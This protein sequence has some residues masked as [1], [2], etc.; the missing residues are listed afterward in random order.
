L[1]IE[2]AGCELLFGSSARAVVVAEAVATSV[3]NGVRQRR[4]KFPQFALLEPRKMYTAG[5]LQRIIDYNRS[6]FRNE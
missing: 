5:S 2:I 3:M 1:S 4:Q 6:A